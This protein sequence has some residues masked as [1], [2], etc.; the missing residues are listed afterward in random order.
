MQ[1][2]LKKKLKLK[3]KK[4]ILCFTTSF[5]AEHVKLF[6]EDPQTVFAAQL[7]SEI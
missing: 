1:H 2:I 3:V 6:P 4:L 5:Q 7:S